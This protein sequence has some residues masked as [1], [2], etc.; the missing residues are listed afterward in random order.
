V[1]F[2]NL[3]LDGL[4]YVDAGSILGDGRLYG[5]L[6]GVTAC[7]TLTGSTGEVLCHELSVYI[8]ACDHWSC[9]FLQIGQ[10]NDLNAA[11]RYL[12]STGGSSAIGTSMHETVTLDEPI[13][14]GFDPTLGW[15]RV[16]IGNN[17]TT[18][19]GVWT[20]SI[21]FHGLEGNGGDPCLPAPGACTVLAIGGIAHRTRR[22]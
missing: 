20:G 21:T 18:G 9:G 16:S 5:T 8:S 22:R 4:A 7:V 14:V 15:T 2:T 3:S 11:Q 13:D 19:S 12:W 1:S 6:T 17:N 10:Y